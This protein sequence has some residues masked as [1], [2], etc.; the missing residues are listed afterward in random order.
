[1]TFKEKLENLR[2][3]VEKKSELKETY[4]NESTNR[5]K[6]LYKNVQSMNN[7]IREVF[8]SKKYPKLI[9]AYAKVG[10]YS[11]NYSEENK[12]RISIV[13]NRFPESLHRANFSAKDGAIYKT[14]MCKDS[15]FFDVIEFFSSL[16]V[17]AVTSQFEENFLQQANFVF[18]NR[19]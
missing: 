4:L 12:D 11:L 18:A 15:T 8:S 6:R 13:E 16:D 10:D 2:Y 1:M 17:E 3:Y 5:L 14:A 9:F 19:V 7:E